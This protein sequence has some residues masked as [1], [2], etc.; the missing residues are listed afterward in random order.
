MAAVQQIATP[1]A[2]LASTPLAWVEE[3]SARFARYRLYRRT[4][5]ELNS[6]TGRELADLGLH[7]S[8]IKRVAYQASY[9]NN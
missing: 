3:L 7:R 6:L 9:E 2:L 5:N 8:M 1:K 4:V